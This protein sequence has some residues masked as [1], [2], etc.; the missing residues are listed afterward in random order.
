VAG[1]WGSPAEFDA[2]HQLIRQTRFPPETRNAWI[3]SA[4]TGISDDAR[5]VA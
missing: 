2:L 5:F 3:E 1:S 4:T